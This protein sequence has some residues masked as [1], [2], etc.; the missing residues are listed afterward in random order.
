M[1]ADHQRVALMESLTHRMS[2]LFLISLLKSMSGAA[3]TNQLG[4]EDDGS[5]DEFR[6]TSAV[7]ESVAT[8]L[9]SPAV[10]TGQGPSPAECHNSIERGGEF[11]DFFRVFL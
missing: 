11:T 7:P 3:D 1:N 5:R 6:R 10:F 8:A 4:R 9:G 2:A